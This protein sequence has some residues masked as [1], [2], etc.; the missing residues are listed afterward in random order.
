M[1]AAGLNYYSVGRADAV[2]TRTAVTPF[3]KHAIEEDEAA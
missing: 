1:Q 3:L 2:S